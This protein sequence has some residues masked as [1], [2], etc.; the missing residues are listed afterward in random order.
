MEEGTEDNLSLE[1]KIQELIKSYKIPLVFAVLAVFL[2]IL[3]L[4]I[5]Q[6]NKES[7][8]VIF[9][10]ENEANLG[11]SVS[12]Q[13][14]VDIE[15]AIVSPGVYEL[16]SGSRIQDLLIR[17]GGLS[18]EADREW[19]SQNLN[20]AAKLIDGGKVYV[21]KTGERKT[22]E[23]ILGYEDIA[24]KININNASLSDLDKLSGVG[25]VTA[26]KI[27]DGRPYQA[28]EDLLSRKIIN[29]STFEK[30]KDKISV[31]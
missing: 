5:W 11:A 26:Q 21:P 14:K 16:V 8:R 25:P 4:V 7:A 29:K 31:Y 24:S 17:A 19:I 20:L 18:G 30:I 9:T 28:I 23:V 12:A 3:A 10:R 1:E 15:G 13:I 27:I 6:S 22:G 2:I